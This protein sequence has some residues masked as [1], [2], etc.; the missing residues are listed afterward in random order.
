ML[1][2]LRVK[3]LKLPTQG[4]MAVCKKWNF[5]MNNYKKKK[6]K[7]PDLTNKLGIKCGIFHRKTPFVI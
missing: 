5:Q 7:P 3:E 2:K 6:K 4:H 1:G